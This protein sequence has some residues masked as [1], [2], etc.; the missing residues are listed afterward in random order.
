VTSLEKDLKV[1]RQSI[2]KRE[3]ELVSLKL[4]I[5]NKD[6]RIRL[7]KTQLFKTNRLIQLKKEKEKLKAKQKEI[8]AA[9]ARARALN[10]QDLGELM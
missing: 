7:L 5:N 3:R 10:S 2:K 6:K 9:L 1:A 8:Q 4:E